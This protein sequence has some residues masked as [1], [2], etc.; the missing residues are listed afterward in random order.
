MG[1]RID[2]RALHRELADRLREEIDYRQ[3]AAN[4]S[5][6]RELFADDDEIEIP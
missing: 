3:E 1:R 4:L 5:R 6:F 2:T